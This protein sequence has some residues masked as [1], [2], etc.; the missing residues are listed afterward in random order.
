MNAHGL[1]GGRNMPFWLQFWAGCSVTVR[2]GE[3]Q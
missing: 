3:S 2:S 1:N